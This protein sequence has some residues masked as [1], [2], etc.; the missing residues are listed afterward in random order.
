MQ[1]PREPGSQIKPQQTM[2][3]IQSVL[4]SGFGP[5]I[6]TKLI[7]SPTGEHLVWFALPEGGS[8]VR[9]ENDGTLGR[10]A[11]FNNGAAATLNN[12]TQ[13]VEVT[14]GQ[15]GCRIAYSYN[16]SGTTDII[17]I[18]ATAHEISERIQQAQTASSPIGI[19]EST[20]QILTTTQINGK[21]IT[22]IE[23]EFLRQAGGFF[24]PNNRLGRD[25]S[26]KHRLAED[27]ET[28]VGL[29]FTHQQL[30]EPLS[31]MLLQFS[32]GSRVPGQPVEY[33]S[34]AYVLEGEVAR[35]FETS[36][37]TAEQT[38]SMVVKVVNVAS[39]ASLQFDALSPREIEEHGFYGGIGKDVS[40]RVS[41]GAIATV[42]DLNPQNISS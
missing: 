5:E 14:R 8:Y 26:L 21:T 11:H 41:P 6:P 18:A 3:Q 25:E 15:L 34:G 42:F 7:D 31:F 17:T 22:S 38:T 10:P 40:R 4:T 12:K 35:G 13:S 27:N 32:S 2:D 24:L 39:G 28:V 20:V 1:E 19:Q 9:R 29:G 30:A 33:N 23:S 36:A 16:Q 37:L